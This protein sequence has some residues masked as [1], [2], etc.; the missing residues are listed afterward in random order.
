MMEDTITDQYGHEH[1]LPGPF[2]TI[3]QIRRHN[4]ENGLFFFSL[5]TMHFF[6]SRVESAVIGGRLFVTSEQCHHSNGASEPR[7]FT[8]RVVADDGD[9]E[10]V[11]K[12]Q[13]FKDLDDAIAHAQEL[14]DE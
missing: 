11:G 7:L 6:D 2:N 13:A 4:E 14:C 9:I 10:T 1:S 5:D 8:I 12:F 3:S